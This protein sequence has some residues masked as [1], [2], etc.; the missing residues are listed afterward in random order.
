MTAVLALYL[1]TFSAV[2]AFQMIPSCARSRRH[3]RKCPSSLIAQ[4]LLLAS[5]VTIALIAL[6]CL[7]A[8]A[9]KAVV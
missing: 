6:R 8:R 1:S 5:F 9:V 3:R 7:P 2:E 4:L